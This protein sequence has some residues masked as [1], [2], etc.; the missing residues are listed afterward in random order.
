MDTQRR[1]D[2]IFVPCRVDLQTGEIPQKL[3]AQ[4]IL[5]GVELDSMRRQDRKASRSP[6]YSVRNTYLGEHNVLVLLQAHG[7]GL[8]NWAEGVD[9]RRVCRR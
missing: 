6:I 5:D 7:D 9:V 1:R 4:L 2:L 8:Q 3:L